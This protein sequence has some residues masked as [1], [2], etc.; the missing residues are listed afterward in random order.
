M[1]FVIRD[2]WKNKV[3]T[4][5]PPSQEPR[6]VKNKRGLFTFD[7]TY[8]IFVFTVFPLSINQGNTTFRRNIV[9]LSSGRRGITDSYGQLVLWLHLQVVCAFWNVSSWAPSLKYCRSGAGNQVIVYLNDFLRQRMRWWL[10]LINCLVLHGLSSGN[11]VTLLCDM[12]KAKT[13]LCK[14]WRHVGAGGIPPLIL[15]I[16]FRCVGRSTSAPDRFI[17]RERTP[18]VCWV[19]ALMGLNIGPIVLEKR[20]ISD[21]GW[22]WTTV[23]RTSGK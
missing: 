6:A 17:M 7:F 19:G 3:P 16:G 2:K 20:E 8:F 22:N 5:G 1:T 23:S 12:I 11:N 4:A 18:G 10:W 9:H 14:R 13:S 21:P 15:N